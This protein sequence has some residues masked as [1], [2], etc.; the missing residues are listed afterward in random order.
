MDMYESTLEI[1]GRSDAHAG[2]ELAAIAWPD[3]VARLAARRDLRRVLLAGEAGH[4]A[5]FNANAAALLAGQAHG[6]RDIN[7][8]ALVD[9]KQPWAN[10]AEA[11]DSA[12]AGDREF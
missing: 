9:G 6:K 10:N 5:S 8:D 7:R 2:Q 1:P 11:A 3:L 4:A 12:A